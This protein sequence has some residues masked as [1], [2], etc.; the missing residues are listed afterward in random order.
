M[1]GQTLWT[2]FFSNKDWP[3]ASAIAVVLL[4]MLVVPMAVYQH[5]QMKAADRGS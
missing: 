2:E 4:C 3:V 1:I 5:L